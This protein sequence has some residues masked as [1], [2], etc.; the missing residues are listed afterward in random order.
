MLIANIKKYGI[1]CFLLTIPIMVWNILL[2]DKLPKAFQAE[3]FWN[4]IPIFLTYGENISRII[5]FACTLLMP[6]SFATTT[7]KRGL[8]LY[9]LG[10]IL[11]FASWLALIYFPDSAWSNHVVG[12]MAPAYTP[13][14][15]LIGIG[16]IG[17]S[18][19]FDLPYKG[20]YYFLI[21]GVF[22]FF[23]NVH[24]FVVYW[25]V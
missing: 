13:L 8:Y 23:H 9:I 21:M 4:D 16:L 10:T 18:F 20:V 6:L 1:N 24:V 11:Y 14:L 17:D 19:Y 2:A 7:Q 12:F 15:W 3:I 5:V 25:R 22:L